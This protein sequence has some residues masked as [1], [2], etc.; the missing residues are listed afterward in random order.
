MPLVK[1]LD[2]ATRLHFQVHPTKAFA[3]ERLD[4]NKGKTEAYVIFGDSRRSHNL[5]FMQGSNVH[6]P[7]DIKE[8]D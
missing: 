3:K 7:R 1:Y 8:M 4:S 5:I 6:Y 2:S